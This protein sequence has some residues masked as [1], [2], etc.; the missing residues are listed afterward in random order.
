MHHSVDCLHC[1]ALIDCG[2]IRCGLGRLVCGSSSTLEHMH[3]GGSTS[4]LST[5]FATR[6]QRYDTELVLNLLVFRESMLMDLL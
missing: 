3:A 5:P 6:H 1:D 4:C 2:G